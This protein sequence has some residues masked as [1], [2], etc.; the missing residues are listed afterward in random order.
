M[1]ATG[2][3]LVGAAVGLLMPQAVRLLLDGLGTAAA[4]Q[5]LRR[6]ML[7]LLLALLAQV[8]LGYGRAPDRRRRSPCGGERGRA[9]CAAA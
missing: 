8:A 1:G 2:V 4:A 5:A 9:P 3:L 6:S 7:L